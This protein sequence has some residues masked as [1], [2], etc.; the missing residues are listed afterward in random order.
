MSSYYSF[1]AGLPDLEFDPGS[2]AGLP[3]LYPGVLQDMLPAKEL[4][5]VRVLWLRKYH[6][7]VIAW[8]SGESN[9]EDLPPE[10]PVESFHSSN[11]AFHTLPIYLRQLVCWKEND[12]SNLP[13]SRVAHRLQTLYFRELLSS[14]NHFMQKWGE[15]EL[16]RLNFLAAVRSE[17]QGKE[18]RQQLIAGNG[19]F[20]LLQEFAI[21]QKIIHTEFAAAAKLES[22]LSGSN[23][24]EREKEM[25]RLSWEAI[26]E[27][28]RFEYF[29][30]DVLLGYFQKVL[31]LERWKDIFSR[32]ETEGLGEMAGRLIHL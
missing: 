10:L 2:D 23:L 18:K 19:Y 31:I 6:L 8:L 1:I 22:L 13:A 3:S 9:G 29:S 4:E 20:E 14:E 5:W 17:A 28:N 24:L 11:E 15:W 32:K 26:D 27:I 30:I 21:T 25:D 7:K 12:R 16:N